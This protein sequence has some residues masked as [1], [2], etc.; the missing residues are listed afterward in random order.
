MSNDEQGVESFFF[1]GGWW[2]LATV[3]NNLAKK[4]IHKT[5]CDC[6]YGEIIGSSGGPRHLSTIPLKNFHLFKIAESVINLCLKKFLTNNFKQV[7]V[8]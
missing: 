1:W 4:I 2:F 7:K 5:G 6:C 3:L 8:F